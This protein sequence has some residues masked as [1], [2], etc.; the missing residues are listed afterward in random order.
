[1]KCVTRL[2]KLLPKT[3]KPAFPLGAEALL[4]MHARVQV[5]LQNTS[6]TSSGTDG[7]SEAGPVLEAKGFNS[8]RNALGCTPAGA[9]KELKTRLNCPL[10][11][12]ET[13]SPLAGCTPV[14]AFSAYPPHLATRLCTMSLRSSP[15]AA[16]YRTRRSACSS[17]H[18]GH[19]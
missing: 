18:I 12:L 3:P 14:G 5:P 4:W 9:S 19:T 8:L 10:D 11:Y 13:P 6:A 7:P 17:R 1:M 15:L 16:S 2:L